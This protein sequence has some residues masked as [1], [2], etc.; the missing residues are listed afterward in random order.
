MFSSRSQT[1]SAVFRIQ[2][3]LADSPPRRNELRH[4]VD[5]ALARGER[6]IVVDCEAWE[7][8]DVV[9]M[10]ALVGCARRCVT[11]G[12]EFELTNLGGEMRATLSDLK[13]A[14]RLGLPQYQ[15]R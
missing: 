15:A 5:A 3:P 9:L 11:E 10:S 7:T 13:L 6:R 2:F 4:G 8:P 14:D 1:N 12:A